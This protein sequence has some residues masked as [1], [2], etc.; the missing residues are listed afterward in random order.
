VPNTPSNKDQCK[1]DG[2]R[3]FTNPTFNNQGD[4]VSFVEHLGS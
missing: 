1:N 2:W 4:C 3:G